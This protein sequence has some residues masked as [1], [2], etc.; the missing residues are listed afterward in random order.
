MRESKVSHFV[1][2][3][4]I[5]VFISALLLSMDLFSLKF[6]DVPSLLIVCGGTL[7]AGA[8]SYSF[9]EV[10]AAI[11][12]AVGSKKIHSYEYISKIEYFAELAVI[13]RTQGDFSLENY[14]RVESDPMIKKGLQLIA[15]GISPEEIRQVLT[16]DYRIKFEKSKYSVKILSQLASVAPAAG[17]IGTVIGLVQMLGNLQ[18][19]Q[20]LSNGLSVALLTTLY[21][22]V[23]SYLCLQPLAT[24]LEDH[25]ESEGI[26]LDLIVEGIVSIASGHGPQI[27]KERLEAFAS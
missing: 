14:A 26:L 17:L 18:N 10:I 12:E 1:K 6:F 3:V 4:A 27:L 16:L 15:D 11:K 24:K 25:L 5:G 13:K 8:V 23:I 2:Y 9:E 20:D 22:A 21:G 19:A 7:L